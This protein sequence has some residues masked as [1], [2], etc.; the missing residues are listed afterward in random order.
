MDRIANLL[1]EPGKVR[2]LVVGLD[3][4]GILAAMALHRIGAEVIAT[5]RNESVPGIEPLEEAGIPMHL[6]GEWPELIK[7]VHLVV[8]S[9]GVRQGPLA[10][11]LVIEAT[12]RGV[13]MV[14]ELE[15]AHRLK[16]VRDTRPI[17]AITGSRGKTSAASL[18]AHLLKQAGHRVFLGGDAARPYTELFL[19]GDVVDWVVLKVSS[20]QLEHLTSPAA[21]VPQIGV[22]LNL[23]P[24]RLDRHMT[25]RNYGRVKRRLFEGMSKEQTGVFWLDESLINQQHEGLACTVCGVSSN[26]ARVP[27]VGALLVRQE[28]TPN[29]W[30]HPFVLNNE[31]LAS[32][33]DNQ[34]AACALSAALAAGLDEETIQAGLDSFQ[35]PDSPQELVE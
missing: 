34:N 35:G 7:K 16:G 18:C 10:A 9:P 30:D 6:G 31:L 4:P 13:P 19:S 22:W 3:R 33:P 32:E 29:E 2:V 26:P 5:D 20:Y 17:L 25:M 8:L 14:G 27:L 24:D 11:P 15:L 12:R 1:A 23:F 21:F 28:V